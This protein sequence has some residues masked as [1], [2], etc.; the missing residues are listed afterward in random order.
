MC[1]PTWPCFGKFGCIHFDFVETCDDLTVEALVEVLKGYVDK[2][3]NN[4]WNVKV[5]KRN[6]LLLLMRS[7]LDEE[8]YPPEQ[9]ER[10]NLTDEALKT[11]NS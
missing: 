2:K 11:L 9:L 5:N 1:S 10:L 8:G 4:R 3:P 6:E 7:L